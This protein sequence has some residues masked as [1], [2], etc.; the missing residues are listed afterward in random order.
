MARRQ[1]PAARLLQRR[2]E[3]QCTSNVIVRRN[4]VVQMAC[5]VLHT[6]LIS[7][8]T[9]HIILTP[10]VKLVIHPFSIPPPPGEIN[11]PESIHPIQPAPSRF[12]QS[13]APKCI[14]SANLRTRVPSFHYPHRRHPSAWNA[15]WNTTK[16][17]PRIL[18]LLPLA[19]YPTREAL[20]KA[21]QKWAK[22]RGYAFTIQ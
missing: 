6:Y 16:V 17:L 4:E 18:A 7:G 20:Y 22:D 11:R 10:G 13:I 5:S 2:N 12:V 14:N 8:I 19:T 3:L 15:T 9:A 1:Y 21:I